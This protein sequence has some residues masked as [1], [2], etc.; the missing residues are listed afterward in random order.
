MAKA[1]AKYDEN[2]SR[3]LTEIDT[4]SKSLPKGT[5]HR[6]TNR[7]SKLKLI[8][9]KKHTHDMITFEGETHDQIAKRYVAIDAIFQAMTKGRHISLMDS[10]EFKVSQMHTCICAIRKKLNR[11]GGFELKD[12]WIETING[13]RCKEYWFEPIM[14]S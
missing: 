6:I 11:H 7:I 10:Q 9:N 3:I 1:K 4:I 14:E 5:Y 8:L 12:K 13:D 2:I